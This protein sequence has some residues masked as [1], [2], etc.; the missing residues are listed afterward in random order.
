MIP[1]CVPS[2]AYCAPRRP[3]RMQK[4]VDIAAAA[5]LP[6]TTEGDASWRANPT[7]R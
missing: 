7:L 1:A 3:P 5:A 2:G 6:D 4:F